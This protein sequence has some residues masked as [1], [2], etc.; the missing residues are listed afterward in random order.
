MADWDKEDH[1]RRKAVR[2]HSADERVR[3]AHLERAVRELTSTIHGRSFLWYLLQI[4]SA[5][6]INAYTSNPQDMAY[7]CGQQKVG[8]MILSLIQDLTPEGWI[9]MLQERL[10]NDRNTR[11]RDSA[12]LGDLFPG[13]TSDD[14]G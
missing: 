11:A 1:L 7:N 6:G 9:A 14:A 12:A 4:S 2:L 13:N 5:Y 10:E 8:Q 3:T